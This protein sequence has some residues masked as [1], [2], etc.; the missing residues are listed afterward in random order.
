MGLLAYTAQGRNIN[1]EVSRVVECRHFC[2]KMWNSVKFA[3]RYLADADY[4]YPGGLRPQTALNFEDQ[5]IPSRLSDTASKMKKYFTD[6]NF[7]DSVQTIYSFWLY[8][9]SQEY[10]EVI[11]QRLRPERPSSSPADIV[12]AIAAVNADQKVARDV[13]YT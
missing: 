1:L 3:M 4:K 2:N 9:L 7:R 11:N 6:Y 8:D 13:L 12:D 10:L 5:W